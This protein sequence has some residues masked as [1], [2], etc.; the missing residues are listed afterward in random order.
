MA[1]TPRL[2]RDI[3]SRELVTLRE[4]EHLE[5]LADGLERFGFRHLPVVDGDKLIG[6]VTQRDLLKASMSSI[7]P[8]ATRDAFEAK[9]EENVFVA[10]L[11]QRD[12]D[13]V[14]PDTT[15]VEAA[16]R[17]RDQKRGCLPVV[18]DDNKLVG[19][20]TETDFLDLAIQLLGG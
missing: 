11:M 9:L 5:L 1:D 14:T 2:V 20:I 10:Q 8:S 3:M 13:T 7:S 17:M 4:E 18:E 15:L 6:L 19:I 16:R 12:V